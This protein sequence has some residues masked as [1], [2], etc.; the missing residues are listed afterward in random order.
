MIPDKSLFFYT[1]RLLAFGSYSK[2]EFESNGVL[3][4]WNIIHRVLYRL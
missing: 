2:V 3:G 1:L 4:W